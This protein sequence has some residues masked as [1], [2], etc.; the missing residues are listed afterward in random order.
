VAVTEWRTDRPPGHGYYL[1]VWQQNNGVRRVS[2]LWYNPDSHG[3][4]WWP[5][6]GY[7]RPYLREQSALDPLPVVAW[8]PMPLPGRVIGYKIG[9]QVFDPA[10]VSVIVDVTACEPVTG[11]EPAGQRPSEQ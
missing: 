6:R 7:L 10:D 5:T 8:A 4:G 9:D 1:A 11:S 3:T 2:E